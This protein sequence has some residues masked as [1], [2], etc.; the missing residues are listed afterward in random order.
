[1]SI[2]QAGAP[3]AKK[4]RPPPQ[5][6]T[7]DSI[8]RVTPLVLRIGLVGA[9]LAPFAQAKPAAHMKFFF[10][11][12]AWP[13]SEGVENAPRPPSRTYTP[14]FYDE[15]RRR[16]EVEFV[17]HHGAGLASDWAQRVKVGDRALV[18]AGPGGGQVMPAD[19]SNVV[20]IADDTSVPAAG[21]IV[22]ALPAA[23]KVTALCEIENAGEERALSPRVAVS[24]AWLHRAPTRARP[25]SLLEAAVAALPP[26]P[27]GARYWIA[28]EAGAMRRIRDY[29]LK[30]R[31][32]DRAM[33]DTRGYWKFG[34]TNYPDHDYGKD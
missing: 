29:L 18:S 14:R 31:G 28:C 20:L 5:A 9:G 15:A 13:P 34:D 19:V 21:M 7:V 25:G 1:M 30:E 17:V 26:Q 16:L 33:M 3:P 12:G 22:E 6:V 11:A 23:C 24:P 8:E 2:T 4:Q 10:H 32:V 27:Q